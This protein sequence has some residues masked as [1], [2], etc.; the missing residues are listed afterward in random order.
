[1]SDTGSASSMIAAWPASATAAVAAVGAGGF[2]LGVL[3]ARRRMRRDLARLEAQAAQLLHDPTAAGGGS[4]D[5][6]VASAEVA[7]GRL[8]SGLWS[9]IRSLEAQGASQQLV[10]QSMTTGVMALD[11]QQRVLSVNAAAERVLGVGG[12]A[13]RGRLLQ[14][15]VRIPELH[16]FVGAALERG[17]AAQQEFRIDGAGAGILHA[18]AEPLLDASGAT[19]GILVT[20][21]DVTAERRL[22]SMRSD[23]AANVSHELRTPI[24]NIK[25][26]A[27]TLLEVGAEEPER[28][29]RF[30]SI[31]AANARRLGQLVEDLLALA[32]LEQPQAR[33]GLELERVRLS[34]LAASVLEDLGR[35]AEARGVR[36][37][38]AVPPDLACTGSRSLLTQ[39]LANLVANAIQWSPAGGAVWIEGAVHPAETVLSVRDEGAGI[40]EKHLPR[41]F[42]RFYRVD[43]SRSRD[44]GG[45][46]L[47][48]A[49][50][51]HIAAVH[52][53]RV[54]VESR[55]GSGSVFRIH[56]PPDLPANAPSL[57]TFL[58]QPGES[59]HPS[60]ERPGLP[61][62]PARNDP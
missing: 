57:H 34:D 13:V 47:G 45:T 39:A 36:L 26:Y 58:A 16:R 17:G 25:G 31:I 53:G 9:R 11:R 28:T 52:G 59:P 21:D 7:V 27:E 55:L 56:L 2:V 41:L 1:M 48:L 40:P 37:L 62:D 30:L 24:T 5:P 60:R 32:S 54:D 20:L 12:G 50:V 46:G 38:V 19:A 22:E 23:F 42:E 3:L 44:S 43:R 8:A 35:V 6:R 18:A 10:F 15:V 14:E 61:N 49:I 4:P 33:L 51:K 29:R